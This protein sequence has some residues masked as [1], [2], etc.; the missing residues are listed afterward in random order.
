MKKITFLL[1][2]LMGLF[3]QVQ[4][5]K[6]YYFHLKGGDIQVFYTDLVDS[7][8]VAPIENLEA[9]EDYYQQVWTADTVFQYKMSEIDS[10]SYV[11][12]PTQYKP[13]VIKLEDGL[14]DYVIGCDSLTLHLKADTPKR[15]LPRVGDKLV[16]LEMTKILPN[17][18]AGEV[19]RVTPKSDNIE[20]ECTLVSLTEIFDQY[21]GVSE[22]N[23]PANPTTKGL[24]GGSTATFG[25]YFWQPAKPLE[26][27]IELSH[28]GESGD[29]A[30]NYGTSASVWLQP[31]LD[32]RTFLSINR[33]ETYVS[34]SVHG[35][36][37]VGANVSYSGSLN[38]EVK[39]FSK[40]KNA[41]IPL[42]Q[43]LVRGYFE[44]GPFLRSALNASFSAGL[45]LTFGTHLFWN[46]S[47]KKIE[48]AGNCCYFLL[49]GVNRTFDGCIEG[50]LQAGVYMDLGI[51]IMDKEIAKAC[52]TTEVGAE[53]NGKGVIHKEDLQQEET[54]YDNLLASGVTGNY[55]AGWGVA[56]ESNIPFFELAV[57][58]RPLGSVTLGKPFM[59]YHL[60]PKFTDIDAKFASNSSSNLDVEVNVVGQ[61][62]PVD[63]GFII[64][65]EDKKEIAKS[66]VLKKYT[67]AKDKASLC[68]HTFLD[69]PTNKKLTVS[70][71]ISFLGQDVVAKPSKEIIPLCPDDHHPHF[72]DLGLPSGTKWACCNVG[73]NIPEG[74]GSYFAMGETSPKACYNPKTY[75]F[76]KWRTEENG[77]EL[78]EGFLRLP[79][80]SDNPQF[81]AAAA[82][83]GDGARMPRETECVELVEHCNSA[84]TTHNGVNG[85]LVTGPNG[86]HI[87]LPAAGYRCWTSL[88]DAGEYGYYWSSTPCEDSDCGAYDL[89]FHNGFFDWDWYRGENGL[90]VRPVHD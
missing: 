80:F 74:Y 81:D 15:K 22:T 4:A 39:P 35:D 30:W 51:F 6:A 12:P 58:D 44:A 56:A 78:L 33:G 57:W 79:E 34:I 13:G 76:A 18:F 42:G 32:I 82:N 64:Q 2:L 73:T 10:I 9:V 85:R 36:Q 52:I 75:K 50:N 46:W 25:H 87:F 72:I 28:D 86:N 14:L 63:V 70:P 88:Y 1:C 11:T 47:S 3:S 61:S 43:P 83:W 21:Y 5:Q 89:I 77:L 23:V 71:M 27:S 20:V 29:F 26:Y 67:G 55:Y 66:Y 60:A 53:I 31:S 7:M 37:T 68:W 62:S 54:L 38:Y 24:W 84:W 40:L 59:D 16:C 45:E 90:P 49:N 48:P 41:G 17:G 65:D 19:V 69:I 8:T